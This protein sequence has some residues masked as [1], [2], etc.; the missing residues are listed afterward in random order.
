MVDICWAKSTIRYKNC[1]VSEGFLYKALT[2][3]TLHF[4][5]R[6]MLGQI[7]LFFFECQL[8]GSVRCSEV[9]GKRRCPVL[10]SVH[11]WEIFIY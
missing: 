10:G 5:R 9:S 2:T 11:Y 6:E 4:Y 7:H 3:S 1:L 8:F